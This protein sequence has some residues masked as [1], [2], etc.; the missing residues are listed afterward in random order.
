M[1]LFLIPISIILALVIKIMTPALLILIA[2]FDN[3]G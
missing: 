1:L 2:G 3:F